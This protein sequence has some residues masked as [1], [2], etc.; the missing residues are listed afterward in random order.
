M[1]I[2]FSGSMQD[3]RSALVACP[4]TWRPTSFGTAVAGGC[5]RRIFRSSVTPDSLS[6]AGAGARALADGELQGRAQ[7]RRGA[8]ALAFVIIEGRAKLGTGCRKRRAAP[9]GKHDQ[10]RTLAQAIVEPRQAVDG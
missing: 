5:C 2:P 9:G 10:R 4:P 7:R 3:W 6:V 1:F 8:G